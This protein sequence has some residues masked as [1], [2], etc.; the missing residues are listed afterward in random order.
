MNERELLIAL[1]NFIVTKQIVQGDND[2]L[3]DMAQRY[4][5]PTISMAFPVVIRMTVPDSHVLNE[6]LKKA[7]VL[8]DSTEVTPLSTPITL[9]EDKLDDEE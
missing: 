3:K 9:P 7:K 4:K 5:N 2:S 1:Y 8:L 6:L